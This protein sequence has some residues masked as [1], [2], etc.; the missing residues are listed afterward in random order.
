MKQTQTNKQAESR[1]K[2]LAK[3]HLGKKALGL[4]DLVYRE[5]LFN[6]AG[7]ESAADLDG[8]GRSAVLDHL[9]KCGF[10]GTIKGPRGYKSFHKS[11]KTSGMDKR[12][13]PERA[14]LLSKIGA[15]LADLELSWAYA[16]GMAERMFGVDKT[17][18]L[19]PDQLHK[20]TAALIYHQKRT[21]ERKEAN[22]RK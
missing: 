13:A 9:R 16:D 19:Y 5:M 8:R 15:I 21:Y 7:V 20:L 6:I 18:W 22:S 2:D 1:R 11:A 17:R 3:I 14:A 12:S 4:S 10:K